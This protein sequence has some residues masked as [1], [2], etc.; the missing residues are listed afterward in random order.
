MLSFVSHELEYLNTA[1][2]TLITTGESEVEAKTP[3]KE[4]LRLRRVIKDNKLFYTFYTL[5]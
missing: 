4:A 1:V 2:K 5:T 3:K